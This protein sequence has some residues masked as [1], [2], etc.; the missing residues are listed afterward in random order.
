M[1]TIAVRSSF[2]KTGAFH[3]AIETL[4]IEST[5]LRVL[6]WPVPISAHLVLLFIARYDHK[7]LKRSFAC[8]TTIRQGCLLAS[9]LHGAVRARAD[10]RASGCSGARH[11]CSRPSLSQFHAHPYSSTTSDSTMQS[12]CLKDPMAVFNLRTCHATDVLA[13]DRSRYCWAML[14]AGAGAAHTTTSLQ[15]YWLGST[16]VC[17]YTAQRRD[18]RRRLWADVHIGIDVGFRGHEAAR[19]RTRPVIEHTI[20]NR[21][22]DRILADKPVDMSLRDALPS[23]KSSPATEYQS[24]FVLL[25]SQE[26]LYSSHTSTSSL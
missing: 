1:Y 16:V 7:D 25:G 10:C 5:I 12:Q 24:E 11:G 6:R 13:D 14:S 26:P 18:R 23:T 3:F 22:H 8:F 17:L 2:D 20:S 21:A 4:V 9:D 19:P 15:Y